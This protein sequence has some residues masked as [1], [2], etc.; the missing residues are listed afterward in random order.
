MSTYLPKVL[1]P[2]KIVSVITT[3]YFLVTYLTLSGQVL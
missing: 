2:Y 1:N 3:G